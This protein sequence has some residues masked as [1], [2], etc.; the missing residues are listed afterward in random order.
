[1]PKQTPQSPPSEPRP[2][3]D[4]EP[5]TPTHERSEVDPIRLE[6]PRDDG[7]TG[8]VTRTQGGGPAGPVPTPSVQHSAFPDVAVPN[9]Q[10]L[11]TKLESLD[12]L[13]AVQLRE[14]AD[15][16]RSLPRE[17]RLD[18]R[19]RTWRARA[20]ITTKEAIS[21]VK[22]QLLHPDRAYLSQVRVDV[23]TNKGLVVPG[24]S[25][26]GRG[27]V[28]D[29]FEGFPNGSWDLHEYKVDSAI[30]SAYPQGP[31]VVV[32]AFRRRSTLGDQLARQQKIIDFARDHQG[33]RLRIRGRM[34]DGR[35]AELL[36]SP[37]TY[38]GGSVRSYGTTAN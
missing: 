24:R 16:M 26:A 5:S 17:R 19:S 33:Y 27:R 25:I 1:M 29:S 30:V 10:F 23:V 2:R 4:P 8:T 9:R 37:E 13:H 36:V 3:R 15:Q 12:R 35:R 34:L 21:V 22:E 31:Q 28:P 6:G 11:H 14:F 20:T 7:L 32:P 18:P 38:R